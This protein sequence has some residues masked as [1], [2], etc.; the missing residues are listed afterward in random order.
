MLK[1]SNRLDR[2]SGESRRRTEEE[3]LR[4]IRALSNDP[5]APRQPWWRRRGLWLALGVMVTSGVLMFDPF[6]NNAPTGPD[7]QNGV[8]ASPRAITTSLAPDDGTGVKPYGP[9]PSAS[10]TLDGNQKIAARIWNTYPVFYHCAAIPANPHLRELIPT[11]NV[12]ATIT[13]SP[14][15]GRYV[16]AADPR[17]HVTESS[18]TEG[19][20]TDYP[21][22]TQVQGFVLSFAPDVAYFGTFNQYVGGANDGK[23]YVNG[24]SYWAGIGLYR[25]ETRTYYLSVQ[26][27]NGSRDVQYVV[28]ATAVRTCDN[29][30]VTA[31][32]DMWRALGDAGILEPESAWH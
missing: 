19:P 28:V 11:A 1:L 21:K 29:G 12:V 3:K 7:A 10:P 25:A 32:A 8:T 16:V 23:S 2:S 4:L 30:A 18:G 5:S 24:K 26:P 22:P 14:K 31:P 15:A 9:Q 13:F 6:G 20:N 27:S 17:I